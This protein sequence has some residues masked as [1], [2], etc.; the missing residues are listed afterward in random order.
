MSVDVLYNMVSTLNESGFYHITGESFAMSELKSYAAGF[1]IALGL[2]D[3]A[4]GDA[5]VQSC[6]DTALMSYA[7]A[8]GRQT[9]GVETEKLRENVMFTLS[10]LRASSNLSG[11][12]D[13]LESY[14]YTGEFTEDLDNETLIFTDVETSANPASY[15]WLTDAAEMLLPAHLDFSLDLPAYTWAQL[16][17][18]GLTV[19]QID[20]LGYRWNLFAGTQDELE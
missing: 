13:A 1:D 18:A 4:V 19:M 20:R 12:T 14:G 15:K 9:E 10:S 11:L 7:A 17:Q 5:F 6:S 3:M 2:I 8:C 16:D